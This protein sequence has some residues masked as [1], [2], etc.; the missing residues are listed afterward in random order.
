MIM[1]WGR[2]RGRHV[3]QCPMPYLKWALEHLDRMPWAMRREMQKLVDADERE[4]RYR[5][6]RPGQSERPA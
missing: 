4:R 3:H 6:G 5:R 1:P 2:Y